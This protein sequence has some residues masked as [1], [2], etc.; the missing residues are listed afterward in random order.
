MHVGIGYDIHA[1]KVGRKLILGGV[2]VPF[3]RGL[4][5]HSDGDALLH[6][7]T[8]A[9][10]GAIG[11]SD[12]GD[13]FPPGEARTKGAGSG[14]FL[15]KAASIV[16]KK[17]FEVVNVDAVILAEAPKISRYK[18]KM[19]QNIAKLLG[20]PV[21]RVGLQAKTNE[22]FDAVGEGRAIACHAVASVVSSKR[23][24]R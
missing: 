24:G 16:A 19:R 9:L 23:S 2:V 12:I 6:A 14:T 13:Y 18:F 8:D 10:L 20:I 5:G 7:L 3:A 22:G 21:S 11:E 4:A 1:L 17:G 15:K